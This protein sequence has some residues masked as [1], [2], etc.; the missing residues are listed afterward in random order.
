MRSYLTASTDGRVRYEEKLCNFKLTLKFRAIQGDL[1]KIV[2]RLHWL[3]AQRLFPLNEV[4]RLSLRLKGPSEGETFS[5][6][7][8]VNFFGT[9]YLGGKGN[10]IVELIQNRNGMKGYVNCAE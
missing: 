5:L 10:S 1:I 9:F 6:R 7:K 8:M 3:N 4:S 2:K